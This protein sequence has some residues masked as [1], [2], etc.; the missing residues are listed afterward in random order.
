MRRWLAG[1]AVAVALVTTCLL[2][3]GSALPAGAAGADSSKVGRVLVFSLPHVSWADIQQYDLPNLRKFLD[4]SGV[5]ALTTRSDERATRLADGY[6]TFAAGT[7]A[8]GD[9]ATDGDN[10]GIDE[11]FGRDTAG[12]VFTQRTGRTV[13]HGIVSLAEPRVIETNDEL[14]YD[15]EIGAFPLALRD[16]GFRRSVIANGDGSQPD[17]PPSA[18]TSTLRRQAA[19]GL[20]LADGRV[21]GG[22]VDESLLERDPATPF[23]VRLDEDAVDAAF[24]EAWQPRSVVMVEASDLVRADAYRP[25]ATPVHREVMHRQALQRS[26]KLLGR[27]LRQVDLKRDGVVVFGPAHSTPQI[28]LTVLGVHTPGTEPGLLRSGT[29]RRAG[30]VQLIDVAPTILDMVGVD[31][32]TSME[33]RPAQVTK[34]GGSADDRID[35]FVR[36]D[37]A[38]QF[39]DLR[40]GEVQVAFVALSAALVFAAI[41]ALRRARPAWV[42]PVLG[43][44]AL[45]LLAALPALFLARLV[46]MYDVGAAGYWAYLVVVA[47]ILG[48]IYHRIGRTNP[49][50]GLLAGLFFNIVLLM[51][52]VLVGTPLEFNSALGYSPTVAGRFAGLSNPAY[53][54]LSASAV[55]AAPLL[56]R[57]ISDRG[58]SGS[59]EDADRWHRRGVWAAIALLV[60]VVI[61][62][63]S[64]F[65]G[66]DV[67]GILSMVPAF[68][69]TA[70]LMLGW[71]IRWRTVGWC[72]VALV[73]AVAG[74]TALDMS[75]APEQR[76]H[77]GRLVERI[78]ERGFGDFVVVIQRKLADNLGSLTHSI[79]GVML[80]ITLIFAIWLV[81]RAPDRLTT[82]RTAIPEAR[83]ALIGF[84]ILAF[85]GYALNDSGIAIPGVMLVVLL[86]AT[87]WLLTRLQ[88][89]A[90]APGK[91]TRAAVGAA[92]S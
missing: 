91:R 20:M 53:A 36:E 77:L 48:T 47:A 17:T 11:R 10:L 79:W 49:I 38:A 69:V 83:S 30:F 88:P 55:L 18:T 44:F 84:A 92:K 43:R 51:G 67:G 52:D 28:T 41:W 21:Q 50:D 64:P 66:S 23:G 39:R 22:Q 62:D 89:T 33:G 35:L 82:L 68:G 90:A 78:Q 42:I 6:L 2:V 24:T 8:V 7:R 15:A 34:E 71:R 29:T 16:A 70:V 37:A 40:V 85:L 76:T 61:V 63:G 81:R 9:P 65:W 80:L 58:R 59:P 72:V 45:C 25:W 87:V 31:R 46:P 1:G 86:T 19:L 74:F 4:S 57:R 75:R 56:A 27:L 5:A 54:A 60:A 73:I 32:P 14:L 3:G 13:R 12:E 26:D